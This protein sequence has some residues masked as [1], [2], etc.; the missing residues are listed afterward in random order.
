MLFK[1]HYDLEVRSRTELKYMQQRPSYR[2]VLQKYMHCTPPP[3]H[4]SWK[5]EVRTPVCYQYTSCTMPVQYNK[6]IMFSFRFYRCCPSSSTAVT[7]SVVSVVVVILALIVLFVSGVKKDLET[8]ESHPI[9]TI[10]F[11]GILMS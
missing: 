1:M 3:P 8:E 5:V 10:I 6:E 2:Y 4:G 11:Q 7:Y 9:P